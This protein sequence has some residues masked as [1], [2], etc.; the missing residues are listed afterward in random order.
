MSWQG[1]IFMITAWSVVIGLFGW[2]FWKV[3]LDD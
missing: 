1:W 3:L 2:S